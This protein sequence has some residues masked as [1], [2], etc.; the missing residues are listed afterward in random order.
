MAPSRTQD[1]SSERTANEGKVPTSTPEPWDTS[2]PPVL[3]FGCVHADELPR[4]RAVTARSHPATARSTTSA[5][6]GITAD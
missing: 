4:T 2:Q 5:I 1:G 6:R 3:H